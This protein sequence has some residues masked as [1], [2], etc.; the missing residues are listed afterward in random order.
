MGF[1]IYVCYQ[2]DGGQFCCLLLFSLCS[3]KR[4]EILCLVS[5]TAG[6]AEYSEADAQVVTRETATETSILEEIRENS[7]IHCEEP[8]KEGND[9]SEEAPLSS[10][11]KEA[12]NIVKQLQL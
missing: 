1:T 3:D 4:C 2:N 11:T 10:S 8:T 9:D 5:P 6:F 12:L 7:M